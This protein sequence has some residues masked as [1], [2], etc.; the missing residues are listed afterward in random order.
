MSWIPVASHGMSEAQVRQA[1]DDALVESVQSLPAQ[2]R[3]E[4]L[5]PAVIEKVV[6]SVLE[7]GRRQMEERLPM[8]M[9]N[10]AISAGAA[11]SH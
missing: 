6:S 3:A 1:L 11:S 9:R 10:M 8:I 5:P 4:G 2:L 7:L